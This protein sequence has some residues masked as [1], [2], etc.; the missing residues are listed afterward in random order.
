M[1]KPVEN[2]TSHETHDPGVGSRYRRKTGRII[3]KDGSFNI[4]RKGADGAMRSFYHYLV[5]ISWTEFFIVTLGGFTAINVIF[6]FLYMFVGADGLQGEEVSSFWGEFANAFFFS[7]QTAT[8]VGYGHV[9]PVGL[10][11][12]IIATIEATIGL[13]VFALMTGLLYGRFSKPT[14]KILFS[15]DAIIAPFQDRTAFMFRLVNRRTNVLMEMKAT[16]MMVWTEE[17]KGEYVRRYYRLPLE[18]DTIHFFPLAWTIVHPIDEESPLYQLTEEEAIEK[19]IEI[20]ILIKGWDDS[21]AQTVHARNSYTGD[22][23]VWGRKFT[24]NFGTNEQGEVTLDVDAVH[25]H[26]PAELPLYKV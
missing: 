19:N 16:V 3:D 9:Y 12:N 20:L 25:N 8:T 24:R 6:A 10:G 14:A 21:F 18:L 26:E 4:R 1:A 22:E 5:G 15:K 17:V 7:V 2:D 13:M 11:A 23:L